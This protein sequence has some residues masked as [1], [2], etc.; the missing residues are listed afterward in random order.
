L[1]F[2]DQRK[3]DGE[4]YKGVD[5]RYRVSTI[6]YTTTK[7]AADDLKKYANAMDK[8]RWAN[9]CC[10]RFSILMLAPLI[11]YLKQLCFACVT[12]TASIP[13]SQDPRDQ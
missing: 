1:T 4:D 2:F 6:K 7:A 3:L 9:G 5:E 8:V 11:S 10:S 13:R 12:G